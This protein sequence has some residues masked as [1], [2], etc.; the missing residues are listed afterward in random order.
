MSIAPS[1]LQQTLPADVAAVVVTYF[2]D[3]GFALRL[4]SIARMVP[5]TVVF[6]NS[7]SLAVHERLQALASDHGCRFIAAESNCGTAAA[8]NQVFAE[9]DREGR[10]W[11]LTFDQDSSPQDGFLDA[12]LR[13]ADQRPGAAVV[14]CNW[15]DAAR[16][17]EPSRHLLHGRAFQPWFSRVAAI[18]D[19]DRV[20]FAISSGS[21][22]N[23]H[24]WRVNGGFLETLFLD[25][26]DVEYCLRARRNGWTVHVAANAHM[27]HRRGSKE[28]ARWGGKTWWPANMP[29]FR[30]HLLIRNRTWLLVHHGW[31]RWP[32]ML[33]EVIHSAYLLFS[34]MCLERGTGPKLSAYFRGLLDGLRGRLGPVRV[35]D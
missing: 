5:N 7:T 14:G 16:P 24:A 4:A 18:A 26:V 33:Y 22:M 28:P 21:L 8:F 32:W 31:K 30:V 10:R 20:A 35:L 25:L 34:L 3:E 2:P 12:L 1:K 17:H 9:F 27:E 13:L 6:D 19:L 29:P 15:R 23:L 11:A